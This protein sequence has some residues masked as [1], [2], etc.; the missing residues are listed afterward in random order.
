MRIDALSATFAASLAAYFAYGSSAPNP[1]DIGFILVMAV[2]FS[3]MILF[4]VRIYNEF[5]GVSPTLYPE[6]SVLTRSVNRSER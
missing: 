1:S 4:W 2:S 6:S 3:Q 5:E